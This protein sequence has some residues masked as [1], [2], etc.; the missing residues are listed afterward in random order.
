MLQILLLFLAIWIYLSLSRVFLEK[1]FFLLF[2]FLFPQA[3]HVRRCECIARAFNRKTFNIQTHTCTVMLVQHS[4]STYV[5]F[6][7]TSL[8]RLAPLRPSRRLLYNALSIAGW[9][10]EISSRTHTVRLAKRL[11]KRRQDICW[12]T[13]TTRRARVMCVELDERRKKNVFMIPD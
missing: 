6:N 9:K 13:P 10:I 12:T 4:T 3:V 5:A 1:V 2:F 7:E 11:W 8:A